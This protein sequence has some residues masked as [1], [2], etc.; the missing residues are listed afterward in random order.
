MIF[1]IPQ[2]ENRGYSSYVDT[3]EDSFFKVLDLQ[4]GIAYNVSVDLDYDQM[5]LGFSIHLD[6]RPNKKN[7]LKVIDNPGQLGE[8][9]I[10]IPEISSDYYLR[11]FSNY[12]WGF[13]EVTVK[14]NLT[15]ISKIVE[16]YYPPFN[17]KIVWIPTASIGGLIVLVL[18]LGGIYVV[19]RKVNW[20]NIRRPHIR[21]PRINVDWHYM[22]EKRIA[23][24]EQRKLRKNYLRE[25]KKV[26]RILTDF[27][28]QNLEKKRNKPE[29][30]K[31]KKVNIVYISD[32]TI[33]C[34]VSGLPIDFEKDEIIACPNCNNVAR[35]PML[36]EWLKV[37]GTCPICRARIV[38][39]LCN[40]VEIII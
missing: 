8:S 33:R 15:G 4:Q 24:R 11:V 5:D 19:I 14:D 9:T 2:S 23:A 40:P 18:I 6:E 25:Q 29:I 32:K 37:K 10:F 16:P 38:I 36:A 34:M 31:E 28:S 3:N 27:R 39:D 17:W 35:K 1:F 20:L 30:K 22:K 13:I 7:A 26:K 21:I 12:D